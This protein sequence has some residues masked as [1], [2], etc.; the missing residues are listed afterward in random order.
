MRKVVMPVVGVAASAWAGLAAATQAT[1]WSVTT[2]YA[3]WRC[4]QWGWHGWTPVYAGLGVGLAVL[5]FMLWPTG[6]SKREN[7]GFGSRADAKRAGLAGA[8]LVFGQWK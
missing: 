2:W 7:T 4:L 6:R 1:V 3:P 8:R 5:A